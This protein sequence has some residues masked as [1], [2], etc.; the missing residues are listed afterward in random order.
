M[1]LKKA[2][3][4]SGHLSTGIRSSLSSAASFSIPVPPSLPLTL[5]PHPRSLSTLPSQ[6]YSSPLVCACALAF[7]YPREHVRVCVCVCV[8]VYLC[9]CVC[10]CARRCESLED[11][12]EPSACLVCTQNRSHWGASTPKTT[13]VFFFNTWYYAIVLYDSLVSEGALGGRGKKSS[14]EFNTHFTAWS[15]R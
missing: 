15:G 11:S 10:V 12:G 2:K 8:F 1:G 3:H 4:A 7:V 6:Q 9:V 14:S 5:T 13:M